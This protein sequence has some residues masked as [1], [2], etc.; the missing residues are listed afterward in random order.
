MLQGRTIRTNGPAHGLAAWFINFGRWAPVPVN[1]WV[2]PVVHSFKSRGPSRRVVR[3]TKRRTVGSEWTKTEAA[4]EAEAATTAARVKCLMRCART[5]AKPRRFRL[6][7]T[8]RGLST[9]EIVSQSAGRDG[10]KIENGKRSNLF[11]FELQ[12]AVRLARSSFFLILLGAGASCT[13][14]PWAGF[15]HPGGESAP[16]IVPHPERR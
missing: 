3:L 6:N 7:R 16:T 1:S 13:E 4:D 2:G 8:P 10:S 14:G 5:V 12:T 9:A 11:P 15:L